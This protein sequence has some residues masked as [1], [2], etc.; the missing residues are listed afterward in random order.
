MRRNSMPK[1]LAK[2]LIAGIVFLLVL[3]L[4]APALVGLFLAREHDRL[5]SALDLPGAV[6]LDVVGFD[7][8]WF[9]S[10]LKLRVSLGPCD[11]P[12]CGVLLDSTIYHGPVPLG[13]PN[14]D[15]SVFVRGIVE[16]RVDSSQLLG[17]IRMQ[18]AAPTLTVVSRLP[19]T[20]G[21]VAHASLPALAARLASGEGAA[22][23]ETAPLSATLHMLP[24]AKP[25]IDLEWP[26]FS[27]VTERGG[28]VS[29]LG[30]N[31]R[32]IG[33]PSGWQ[34]YQFAVDNAQYAT[35]SGR[36]AALYGLR[37]DAAATDGGSA[38]ALKLSSL[39]A[40][41][42]EYGPFLV[43]GHL[44]LGSGGALPPLVALLQAVAVAADP[45]TVLLRT[46][47]HLRL[48]RILLGTPNGDV[49]GTLTLRV[50]AGVTAG[51][52]LLAALRGHAEL[53][54][55][56]ALMENVTA[57]VMRHRHP[58][59]PAPTAG[60]V[61]EA[62]AGWQ[63]RGFIAYRADD[64]AYA[65]EVELKGRDLIINGRK[66]ENWPELLAFVPLKQD[67]VSNPDLGATATSR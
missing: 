5:L 48:K 3:A 10:R 43:R 36:G 24:G 62:I 49:R 65:I 14:V 12:E 58:R 59:Q 42:N 8:G 20:G 21:V 60:R 28:Q 39:A 11:D 45:E 54:V 64:Q 35:A 1:H 19:L 55:P 41:G 53:L 2:S 51:G 38:L 44:R 46:Q 23:I 6:E 31:A 67:G 9:R 32:F 7:R 4:A 25:I 29:F 17:D 40:R 27:V 34:T 47:P 26:Q 22:R 18:P 37:L 63:Q 61:E 56:A 52:D 57:A 50:D 30:L 66:L 33:G 16:T 15:G 13:A